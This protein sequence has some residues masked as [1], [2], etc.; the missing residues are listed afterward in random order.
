MKRKVAM[1]KRKKYWKSWKSNHLI[2]AHVIVHEGRE[3]RVL[4]RKDKPFHF[5]CDGSEQIGE[6]LVVIIDGDGNRVRTAIPIDLREYRILRSCGELHKMPQHYSVLLTKLI[7]RAKERLKT[8]K[9]NVG[10]YKIKKDLKMEI[11]WDESPDIPTVPKQI[12][13]IKEE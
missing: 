10:K 3:P 6:C 9:S 12:K 7:D 11:D 4:T 13:V 8:N 1:Q 5:C 2:L